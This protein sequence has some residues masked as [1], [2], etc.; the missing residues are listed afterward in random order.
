M[1]RY[2]YRIVDTGRHVEEQLNELGAQG[3]RVVGVTT[4]KQLFI[5]P[6]QAIILMREMEA[7]EA[8]AQARQARSA[9]RPRSV[10]Q[11]LRDAPHRGRHA[12]GRD[13][14]RRHFDVPGALGAPVQYVADL[15]PF[16]LVALD[17]TRPG[18]AR[19]E[20][21]TG[22]LRWLDA[23]LTRAPV[24]P[25]LLGAAPS[26]R[27]DLDRGLGRD[28][29]AGRRS[30][31]TRRGGGTSHASA[32]N[33]C[34]S[35]PP[36]DDARPGRPRRTRGAQHVC[37][38]A[39][40]LQLRRDRDS[41]RAGRLRSA[42]AARRRAHL[43]RPACDLAVLPTTRQKRREDGRLRSLPQEPQCV[44]PD[45]APSLHERPGEAALV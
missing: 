33:C 4:K 44:C 26:A 27:L 1:R 28:R 36:H 20:L 9:S 22:R 45:P 16:R 13:K 41:A 34:R 11:Q 19:G 7:V 8:P 43:A 29:P 6:P 32:A 12:A 25:T 40:Q 14:L 17:S 35:R 10:Y 37:P 39:P 24:R 5:A 23:E 15:G 18:E 3:W 21:D 42:C 2:E 38:G 31:R 30:T